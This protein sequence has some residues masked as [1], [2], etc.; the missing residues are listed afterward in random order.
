MGFFDWLA[1]LRMTPTYSVLIAAIFTPV[2][3]GLVAYLTIRN[4]RGLAS[5]DRAEKR[6]EKL[7]DTLAT[8][9]PMVVPM[10]STVYTFADAVWSWNLVHND[11]YRQQIV[12][13]GPQAMKSVAE[14]MH[15]LATVLLRTQ[16]RDEDLKRIVSSAFGKCHNIYEMVDQFTTDAHINVHSATESSHQPHERLKMKLTALL[17]DFDRIVAEARKSDPA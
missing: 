14:I 7:L 16:N 17:E 13:E 12:A 5:R 3:T 2:I 8:L 1:Q 10:R 6:Y 9:Q 11:E 4:Q 15:Q